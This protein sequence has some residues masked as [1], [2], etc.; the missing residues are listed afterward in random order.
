MASALANKEG[1]YIERTLKDHPY[2]HY[3]GHIVA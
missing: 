2:A 3:N 1:L